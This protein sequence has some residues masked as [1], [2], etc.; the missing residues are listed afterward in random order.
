MT[1]SAIRPSHIHS[2]RTREREIVNSTV[3]CNWARVNGNRFQSHLN[4]FWAGAIWSFVIWWREG[5]QRTCEVNRGHL[6]SKVKENLEL[7]V[8]IQQLW[9]FLYLYH[10]ACIEIC[11]AT[12]R[13]SVPYVTA[14]LNQ[15]SQTGSENTITD[16]KR[17][18]RTLLLFCRHSKTSKAHGILYV[19]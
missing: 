7:T 8:I 3:Q 12:V 11:P 1:D 10:S 19:K 15:H 14:V 17:I 16:Q 2:Q 4:P 18:S 6:R 13:P 9:D 5:W